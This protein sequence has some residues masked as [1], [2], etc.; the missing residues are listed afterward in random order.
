MLLALVNPPIDTSTW[1]DEPPPGARCRFSSAHVSTLER[2]RSQTTGSLLVTVVPA[3]RVAIMLLG[4]SWQSVERH[5]TSAPLETVNTWVVEPTS[6]VQS[7]EP[8]LVSEM[9]S[10]GVTPAS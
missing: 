9:E 1:Y 4:F 3:A 7:V 2:V 8:L 10:C 6:I 5:Q